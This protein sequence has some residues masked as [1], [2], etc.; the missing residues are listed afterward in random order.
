MALPQHRTREHRAAYQAIREAQAR[1]EWLTCHQPVCQYE[2]RDIPPW[3]PA[4]VCHD[5]T[6]TIILGPGHAYC[7]ESEAG[8]KRHRLKALTRWIL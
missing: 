8:R 6:G 3:E 7:N 1:G 2:T 4:H 5:D